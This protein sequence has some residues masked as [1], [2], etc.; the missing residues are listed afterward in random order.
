[1]RIGPDG[2]LT[3]YPIGVERVP[4]KWKRTHAGPYAPAFEPDD[5]DATEPVLIEEPLKLKPPE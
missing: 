1:M 3:L 5:L 2:E 4:R